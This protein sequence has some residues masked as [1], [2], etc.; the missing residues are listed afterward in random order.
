MNSNNGKVILRS[1]GNSALGQPSTQEDRTT[2]L[3]AAIEAR[4]ARA[5]QGQQPGTPSAFSE[6]NFFG[7]GRGGSSASGSVVFDIQPDVSEA[8]SAS[9]AEFAEARL[10]SSILIYQGTPARNFSINAKM[11]SRTESEATANYGKLMMLKSWRFPERFVETPSILRLYGYNG[12]FNGIYTVMTNINVEYSSEV[13][14]IS[15]SGGTR[16]PIV[17]D[18]S[19]SLKEAQALEDSD[20][21]RVLSGFDITSFRQGRLDGW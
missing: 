13:D 8:A 18:V 2:R 3:N 16:M 7:S 12:L 14:Y 11:I 19:I 21:S 20:I 15:T 10:P 4:T 1:I 5:G 9:Y 17:M 6:A